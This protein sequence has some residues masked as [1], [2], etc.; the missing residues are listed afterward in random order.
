MDGAI[1][2]AIRSAIRS[3][4]D[5]AMRA[6]A[7]GEAIGGA[8]DL[9]QAFRGALDGGGFSRSLAVYAGQPQ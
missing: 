6:G 2:G 1:S 3:A 7:L 4:I 8:I 9:T 5:G